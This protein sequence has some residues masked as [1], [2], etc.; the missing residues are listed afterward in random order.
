MTICKFFKKDI[1]GRQRFL[2]P[3]VCCPY[4]L[5]KPMCSNDCT[6]NILEWALKIPKQVMLKQERFLC[7]EY[8]RATKILLKG[9]SLVKNKNIFV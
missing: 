9:R 4:S 5:E 8:R 3:F 2:A 7:T 6:R 1:Q